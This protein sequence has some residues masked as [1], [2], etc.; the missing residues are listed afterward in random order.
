MK[1]SIAKLSRITST[2]T[3]IPE[4]DGIRF[5]AIFSV[6]IYHV[7][8]DIFRHSAPGYY[9]TVSGP[10]FWLTQHGNFGVQLFFVLSGFAAWC[11][12]HEAS[13]LTDPI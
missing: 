7:S 9:S 5:I 10:V 2:G 11:S 1:I 4:V 12:S 8:G 13:F 3:Y 6:I